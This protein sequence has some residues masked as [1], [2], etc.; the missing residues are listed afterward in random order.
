MQAM[1]S[2]A[3]DAVRLDRAVAIRCLHAG[4]PRARLGGDTEDLRRFAVM[5]ARKLGRGQFDPED[6]AHEVLERWLRCASGHGDGN[7]RAWVAVVL[8]RLVVDRL[9]RRR[10][11]AEVPADCAALAGAEPDAA[12]WWC[13]L[14]P[15][16]LQRE[17][18][19]LPPALRE[20]FELF[21]FQARSY[22]Q[23]AHQQ[24]IA[25]GTV[26]T[27]IN[28]ARALLRRRLSEHGTGHSEARWEARCDA[29]IGDRGSRS[30]SRSGPAAAR[31]L[32]RR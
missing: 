18:G 14:P 28:R 29:S 24:N 15:D 19:R 30:S 9:R 22:Q 26:G 6:L 16:V 23:I 7:P 13:D 32:A 3:C 2:G 12:P 20:T 25:M 5:L 4:H 31:G 11:A 17:L 1:P 27:R 8:R 10:T 21:S